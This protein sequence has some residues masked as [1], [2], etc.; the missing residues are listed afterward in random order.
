MKY[1][2]KDHKKFAFTIV[3]D[4]DGASVENIKPIY[5]YLYKKGIITTKTVWMYSPR[6]YFPGDSMENEAYRD[7]VVGLQKQGYEIALHDAG[8]GRFSSAEIKNALEEFREIFGSYPKMQINHGDNPS[9]IYWCGKRFSPLLARLYNFY[10][11]K[12]GAFVE[13]EGDMPGKPAFWGD[14]CKAHIRYIRNRVYG[15]LNLLKCD[16]Y[17]PY[18]EKQKDVYSNYW[19]SSSD[20]MTADLFVQLLSKRNIDRL[21]QQRGCAIVYTHFG[22][23]F[24]DEK[25]KKLRNDV[26][27]VLDYLAEQD[28]WFAPASEILDTLL[29][30]KHGNEYLS[31]WKS[32]KLDIRWLAERVYRRLKSKV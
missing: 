19:F 27:E 2:W 28:G 6:D 20:A 13:S 21:V 4:T 23:G 14:D 15:E 9:S 7:Y 31:S 32:L 26:K 29:E 10:K 8:S 16:P 25:T 18:R 11:K 30:Q 12:K 24:V 3:D 5:Q 1:T 22:Y 17:T